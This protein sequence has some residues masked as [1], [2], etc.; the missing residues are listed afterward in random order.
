MKMCCL[1]NIPNHGK[2]LFEN[3]ETLVGYME[4]KLQ[5]PPPAL[6]SPRHLVY[7]CYITGLD[8][9]KIQEKVPGKRFH[10]LHDYSS[11]VTDA[12]R[13]LDEGLVPK[14]WYELINKEISKIFQ[15]GGQW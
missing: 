6:V 11:L 13:K 1:K 5:M 15:P 9:L 10:Y 7:L 2:Y 12:R 4:L 3:A 8:M 14:D